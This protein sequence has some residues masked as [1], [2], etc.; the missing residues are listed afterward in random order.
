MCPNSIQIH[1]KAFYKFSIFIKASMHTE[2]VTYLC[3]LLMHEENLNK[4]W[5]VFRTLKINSLNPF[6]FAFTVH[7]CRISEKSISINGIYSV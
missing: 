1:F 4:Y 6:D 3:V 5:I 2:K 7:V